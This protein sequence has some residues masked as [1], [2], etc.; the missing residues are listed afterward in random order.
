MV[1]IMKA[2]MF[3]FLQS[4]SYH[5]SRGIVVALAL[6]LTALPLL[7]QSNSASVY[8]GLSLAR[9][10]L[11][12][13]TAGTSVQLTSAADLS[14][15]PSFIDYPSESANTA[16]MVGLTLGS[17]P[18]RSA[19]VAWRA[20]LETSYVYSI[21]IDDS[22]SLDITTL[23]LGIGYFLPAGSKAGLEL[24]VAGMGGLAIGQVGTVGS[25]DGDIYLISPDDS[26]RYETGS[27]IW[28][29]GFGL[30]A[31]A[32]LT[33]LIGPLSVT[34]GYR[35]A[36]PIDSWTYQ[37]R[38][39]D[40]T[41]RSSEL[42]EEGFASNPPT[43]DLDGAYIRFGIA[44]PIASPSR[45]K[46]SPTPARPLPTVPPPQESDPFPEVQEDAEPIEDDPTSEPPNPLMDVPPPGAPRIL[47]V[48]KQ[49]NSQ[50]Y[51]CGSEDGI[52]GQRTRD[53][54]RALQEDWNLPIT[55][56][57]DDATLVVIR[58]L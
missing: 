18:F 54:I 28:T 9:A 53:C 50:G 25:R 14:P 19:G 57:L 48:Q 2:F 49:L 21:L 17:R 31:D 37:V 22:P 45:P 52:L 12:A 51:D 47:W 5:R 33:A 23:E 20:H 1:E 27:E 6:H 3:H 55:G 13:A 11:N 15:F 41:N 34:A 8:A 44:L 43:Y 26:E 4:C 40:D 42:P 24:G 16:W 39:V 56:E 32:T 35:L 36:T 7:A 38:D 10:P 46:A 29:T 30:G 58:D